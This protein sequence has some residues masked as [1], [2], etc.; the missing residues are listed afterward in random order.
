MEDGFRVEHLPFPMPNR[1]HTLA[2]DWRFLTFMH[3]R[4]DIE[5]LRH[6]VPEGLEIDTFEGDAY[7]GLVPF[8]M[9]HVRPSWFVSTPGISNF[10]EFNIR[11]YVKKDGIA[12]V[13]FLTL[14][15]KSLVTCDFAP[16]TYG[17]PYRY[18]KGNVKK[19][20]DKWNWRSSSN[21]GQFKLAGTTEVIGEQMQAQ[22]GSLEEF[23]FER[24]S[25]Y[26]SHKGSLRRGYTHHNKWKFQLAKVK[27]TENSL[28]ESFNLGIDELLTPEL[29]HYSD[30]VRVRTYSIEL[31]ERIGTD[32]NRDFLLLDG[33]CGLCHRLATF[34]DKRMKTST[35]LGYRPNSSQD[36]QRLIQAMPKKYSESDTVY[37]VRNGQ[38]YM[39]SSAAIRCL[40]YMKW[41][42]RMWYPVCWLIPLPLRDIAYRIVA[43]YR[44]KVFKK[45]KV[46]AFRVD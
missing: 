33:D 17:L 24:Y 10:P 45:P 2:Q 29:V 3:W 8:M 13:F 22:P 41:Y 5:K 18:A 26:T 46:C 15:A 28:T 1:G 9:K 34:L 21:N 20:G 12:G 25:L 32:I 31:A 16:R 44:H 14:E 27:L 40:L 39:R 7:I 42:Y 6:H 23:L 35:N 37:L 43:K 11:T 38:P 19:S 30:G 36:A 4:V